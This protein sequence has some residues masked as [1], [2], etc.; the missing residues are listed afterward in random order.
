MQAQHIG[1]ASSRISRHI[2]LARIECFC[3]VLFKCDPQ[4]DLGRVAR[5]SILDQDTLFFDTI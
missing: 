2:A 4:R 5:A 3:D 1:I